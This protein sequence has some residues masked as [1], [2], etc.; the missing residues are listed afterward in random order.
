MQHTEIYA[1]RKIA[2]P[3]SLGLQ[4]LAAGRAA[5][6]IPKDWRRP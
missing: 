2:D 5:F 4:I 6:M 3:V 1:K